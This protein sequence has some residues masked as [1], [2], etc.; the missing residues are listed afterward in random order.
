MGLKSIF[1]IY[2]ETKWILRCFWINHISDYIFV[3]FVS[4]HFWLTI[5]NNLFIKNT[6]RGQFWPQSWCCLGFTPDFVFMD[7]SWQ[8]LGDYMCAGI[9][10]GHVRQVNYPSNTTAFL[11]LEEPRYTKWE[12][13]LN[14]KYTF[15][16]SPSPVVFGG[17]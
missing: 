3:I 9:K 17:D 15:K 7:H 11:S 2:L 5:I 1:I 10:T 8:G 12:T 16:F 14:L 13:F 6:R 4:L